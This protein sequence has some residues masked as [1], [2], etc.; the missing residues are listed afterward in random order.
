[1]Y[2]DIHRRFKYDDIHHTNEETVLVKIVMGAEASQFTLETTATFLAV[3][4]L[5]IPG[6]SGGMPPQENFK[7]RISQMPFP[8]L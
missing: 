8:T 5:C 1:M 4:V 2:D 6:G 7:T 3:P